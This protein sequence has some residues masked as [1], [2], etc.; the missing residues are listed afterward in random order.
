MGN[1]DCSYPLELSGIY[2]KRGFG[3]LKLLHN[4]RR[5]E[6]DGENIE[7]SLSVFRNPIPKY[8]FLCGFTMLIKLTSF[9][10]ACQLV[11]RHMPISQKL[12]VQNRKEVLFDLGI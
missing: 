4:L 12:M 1:N 3:N 6:I 9:C 2:F 8:N 7:N 11:Y 5:V 10:G